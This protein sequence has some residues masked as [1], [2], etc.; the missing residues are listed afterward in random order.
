[1][2][3]DKNHIINNHLSFF[4]VCQSIIFV[5]KGEIQNVPTS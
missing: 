4:I 2:E 3:T 5:M 1:M